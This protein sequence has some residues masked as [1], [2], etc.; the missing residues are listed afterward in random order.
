VT[1][2]LLDVV[3]YGGVLTCVCTG[4]FCCLL[5]VNDW[6]RIEEFERDLAENRFRDD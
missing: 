4:L 5:A 3:V 2:I 1:E 6:P